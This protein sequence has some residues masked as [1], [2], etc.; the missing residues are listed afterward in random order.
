MQG[1]P[2]LEGAMVELFLLLMNR[3]PGNSCSQPRPLLHIKR[4]GLV[5]LS[6]LFIVAGSRATACRDMTEKVS[7]HGERKMHV[8]KNLWAS[9]N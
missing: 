6:N 2:P 7:Y 4:E 1:L 3:S 8:S 5:W 9:L